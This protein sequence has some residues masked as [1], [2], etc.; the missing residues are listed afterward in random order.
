L[1]LACGTGGHCIE[2][3]KLGYR[4]TGLDNSRAMLNEAKKKYSNHSIQ[5]KLILGDMRKAYST[6]MNRKITLP[7]DAIICMGN[8]L[9]H[10]IDDTMLTG[11]LNEVEKILKREGLFIFCVQNAECFRDDLMKKLRVDNI[12]NEL[13]LQLALL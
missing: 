11:T 9:A 8:S 3:S 7:F 10:M 4:V 5:S 2:L 6:L 13:N 12:I 1:D